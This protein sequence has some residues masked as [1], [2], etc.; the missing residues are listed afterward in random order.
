MELVIL[1]GSDW[2]VGLILGPGSY[3]VVITTK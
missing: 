2:V 3:L 1:D